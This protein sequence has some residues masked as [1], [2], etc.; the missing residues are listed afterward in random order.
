MIECFFAN[1]F[2]IWITIK[3]YI[4]TEKIN[5]LECKHIIQSKVDESI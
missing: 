4:Y 3:G 2:M 5:L 1:A